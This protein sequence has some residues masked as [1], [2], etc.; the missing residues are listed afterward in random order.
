M[1]SAEIIR[2]VLRERHKNH[3]CNWFNS[4]KIK[5]DGD[6][7][8][9]DN[10]VLVK[11]EFTRNGENIPEPTTDDDFAE[12][13]EAVGLRRILRYL[14]RGEFIVVLNDARE[15]ELFENGYLSYTESGMRVT[16]L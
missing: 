16:A 13:K 2:Q 12:L 4:L 6:L 5:L 15:I 7:S 1:P 14:G 10:P 8:S 3:L 9:I 11:I